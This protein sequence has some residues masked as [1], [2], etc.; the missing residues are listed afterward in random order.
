MGPPWDSISD[1]SICAWRSAHRARRKTKPVESP[2]SL[3]PRDLGIPV[4][5]VFHAVLYPG[6]D[7]NGRPSILASMGQGRFA[8]GFLVLDIDPASGRCRQHE[9]RYPLAFEASASFRSPVTGLLYCGS[10]YTGQLH[11][12][13]AG[14]ERIEDLG[15]VDEKLANFPCR[16]DEAADGSIYVGAYPGCCLSR[17]NPATGEWTRFGRM[18]D[19]DMYFYPFCG[20]DGTVA[21]LVKMCRPHV[22]AFDPGSGAQR[23]VGPVVDTQQQTGDTLDLVKGSDGLLYIQSSQGNFRV[24]GLEAI[25]VTQ[26]PAP[27]PPA[28]LP[29]GA[30]VDYLDAASFQWRRIRIV[31]PAGTPRDLDLNW[32][33]AGS[34]IFYIHLGPDGRLYGSSILPEHLFSCRLDGSEMVNHGQCSVAGG[35]AYSMA[36]LDGKLYIASYP[37]A[38]LSIYD[39]A[40]PY[41]FGT[42]EE[43]NPRDV[44]RPDAVAYRPRAMLASPAGRVWIGSIP[45]YG[46]WGG[47]LASYDPQTGRFVSHRHLVQDCGVTALAWLPERRRILVGTSIEG[48]TGTQ[49]RAA[50]AA[51]VYWDPERDRAD[52]TETFG[53]RYVHAV[54]DLLP[55]NERQVYAVVIFYNPTQQAPECFAPELLL[56]DLAARQILDRSTLGGEEGFPLEISLRHGPDGYVYGATFTQFYRIVPGTARREAL[57]R[58][59]VDRLEEHIGIAGPIVGRTFY[60]AHAHRLWAIDIPEYSDEGR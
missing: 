46:M 22:V 47:T 28:R 49:P 13:A 7:A 39:P 10:C 41:R 56:I 42:G 55:A 36:N 5:A 44:G 11:R 23:A 48:G 32:Q 34:D 1:F 24:R 58:T 59:T 14:A 9:C 3:Q 26:V 27:L 60:C 21:G 15:A 4:R 12:F 20:A 8:G 53:L 29:D 43:A 33:G 38:R 2:A 30:T 17:F 16:I 51:F 6:A 31:S 25:P 35:E 52:G 54:I 37:G 45:D 19:T 40:K 18:D 57:Y 50:S